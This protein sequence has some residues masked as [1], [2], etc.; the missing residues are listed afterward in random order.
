MSKHTVKRHELTWVLGEQQ[1]GPLEKYF[2]SALEINGHNVRF[3]NIHDLYPNSWRRLSSYSHRLPRKYDNALASKYISVVNQAILEKFKAE[4]PSLIFIYNDCLITPETIE[5]FK[6]ND[7]KIITFLGDD[8]NYIQTGKKTFLLTTLYSDAVIV[9]DTGWITGLKM[10]GIKKLIFSP[11]GTDPEIFHPVQPSETDL[12][13]F[14]SAVLFVGTGYYLNA[15]GIKRAQMLSALS[16]LNFKLFGDKQWLDLLPYFPQLKRN[17]VNRT[18]AADEVN[19]A[20]CCSKIYPVVVNSGVI[21]GVSTR[22]FDS[23]ASGIFVLAE[24][25]SD[26][27]LL[28]PDG[29]IESFIDRDDLRKKAEYFLANENEMKERTSKAREIILKKYTLNKLV[30]DILEQI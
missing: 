23:I 18:L 11:I 17:F 15:W 2:A 7:A 12:R 20:S 14:S 1:L 8:P 13:D 29:E 9:P 30:G 4:R 10:L 25:K 5:Y 21:N 19:R 6:R 22:I 16:D 26:L 3:H 28:F 24:Y 27:D